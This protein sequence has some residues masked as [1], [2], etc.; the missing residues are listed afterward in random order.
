MEKEEKIRVLFSEE[1]IEKRVSELAEEIGRDYAGKELHLVCILKGAA[2]FMCELAKKLNN[3]GVSM[4]F[5]AV[6]SY[7]SQTQSSG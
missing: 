4:D 3:P 2:P 6:S 7:G 1:E 5:M